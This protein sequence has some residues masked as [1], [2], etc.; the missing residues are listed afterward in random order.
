MPGEQCR[1]HWLKIRASDDELAA[2]KEKAK[3][4]GV[5]LSQLLRLSIGLVPIRNRADDKELIRAVRRLGINMNQLAAWA[6][7]RRERVQA[8]TIIRHLVDLE[9]QVAE[10]IDTR[11][12]AE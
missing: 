6:N 4:A 12:S 11:S 5:S 7:A 3:E 10:L 8:T 9:R 1:R 2:W